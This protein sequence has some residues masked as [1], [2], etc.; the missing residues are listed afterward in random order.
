MQTIKSYDLSVGQYGRILDNFT[1][2]CMGELYIEPIYDNIT[3]ITGFVEMHWTR[4][5]WTFPDIFVTVS[6]DT[7][8]IG[9]GEQYQWLV[10]FQCIETNEEYHD[11]D[12]S[13]FA[14]ANDKDFVFYIG[15][16]AY[17]YTPKPSQ[18]LKNQMLESMK[19]QGLGPYMDY[20][21]YGVNQTNCTYPW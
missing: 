16:N 8:D 10:E 6:N 14:G 11:N 13:G 3:N 9:F 1:L 19:A 20:L 21:F 7:I 17:A 5:S 18:Q 12:G 2:D 4:L 15:I